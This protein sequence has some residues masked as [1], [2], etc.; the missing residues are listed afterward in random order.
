MEIW[1]PV[2]GYE[3]IYEV[4][5]VGNVRRISYKRTTKV[6]SI[7]QYFDYHGYA[8]VTLCKFGKLYG[9]KVHRLVAEAFIPNPDKLPEVNH[10]DEDKSNNSVQNLEWCDR[11]Y[12]IRYSIARKIEQIHG[13]KSVAKWDS[14]TDAGLKTGI[15]TGDI[16]MCCKGKLKSAGGYRWRYLDE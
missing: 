1:K 14:I 4:S 16:S 15:N 8:R 10:K 11:K 13:D 9:K 2:L 7:R 6:K 5:D 12:N 3:G